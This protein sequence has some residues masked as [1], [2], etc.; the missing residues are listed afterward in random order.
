MH[1]I[2]L[3]IR[4]LK[5]SPLNEV[6]DW[7]FSF[8][9][10][11]TLKEGKD[12]IAEDFNNLFWYR[13][14]DSQMGTKALLDLPDIRG[15]KEEFYK[16]LYLDN[17]KEDQ[18]PQEV[19]TKEPRKGLPNLDPNANNFNDNFIR[20]TETKA[21]YNL[22]LEHKRNHEKFDKS[23]S[24]ENCIFELQD[25]PLEYYEAEPADDWRTSMEMTYE[26]YR[27]EVLIATM[28][29]AYEFYLEH[30]N[31]PSQ[32]PYTQSTEDHRKLHHKL[33]DEMHRRIVEGRALNGEPADLNF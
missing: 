21:F 1:L 4:Y 28:P 24:A 16:Q 19:K 22:F 5:E 15:Q 32:Y 14:Y 8:Q 7:G 18:E 31:D 26:R 33:L 23:D 30:L 10:Y 29:R 27:R 13:F 11:K 2:D 25:I 9:E 20:E 12:G 3:Y 6:F 17:E